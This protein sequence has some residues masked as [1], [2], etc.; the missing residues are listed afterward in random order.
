MWGTV[1]ILALALASGEPK[2]AS[3]EPLLELRYEAPSECPSAVD[4]HREVE[5]LVDDSS[6]SA[7]RVAIWVRVDVREGGYSL[8]LESPAGERELTGASCRDVTRAAALFVALLLED[9]RYRDE[10]EAASSSPSAE[11]STEGKTEPDQE[12][13]PRARQ[14]TRLT[15]SLVLGVET[16]LLPAPSPFGEIAIGLRSGLWMFEAQGHGLMWSRKTLDSGE[17]IETNAWG[18]GLRGCVLPVVWR[19]AAL[20]PCV[21][22]LAGALFV[23]V[24]DIEDPSRAAPAFIHTELGGRLVADFSAW[25][26]LVLTAAWAQPLLRPEIYLRELDGEQLVHRASPAL[27]ASLGLLVTF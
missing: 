15:L 27:R 20:G 21:G 26:A 8:A 7:R 19:R 1:S 2:P 22:V 10:M 3:E 12:S 17:R 16:G 14:Q 25:G 11:A 9:P 18:G 6:N 4:F 5:A 13:L 24:S 23:R